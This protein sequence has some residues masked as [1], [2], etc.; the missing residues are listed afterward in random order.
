MGWAAGRWVGLW[1]LLPLAGCGDTA[2]DRL[3]QGERARVAEVPAG[4]LLVLEDGRRV[5][6]AGVEAP[7]EDA[8]F[9]QESRDALRRL[10]AGQEIELLY[11]GARKD[12]FGRVVAQVRTRDRRWVEGA[13]LDEGAVRVRT[14]ADNRALAPQMLAHEA[15]ARKQGRGLWGLQDYQV[16]L[17]EELGGGPGGFQIVESRVWRSGATRELLYLDFGP[18]WRRT[19]SVEIPRRALKEFR[20]AGLEPLSLEG[21]MIRVRG[22]VRDGRLQVDHPAQVELVADAR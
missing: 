15:A 8:P 22:P 12:P 11:G 14:Y 4:D 17:P 20:A 7:K 1:L 5:K 18:D 3:A 19:V 9:A 10:V 6:L 16:R 13:L 21:R 2:L